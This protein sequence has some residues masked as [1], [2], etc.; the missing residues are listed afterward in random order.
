[1]KNV[2][3][4]GNAVTADILNGYMRRDDR[5]NVL[6]ATVDDQ[7]ADSDD[8]RD[9][10]TIKLSQL[11]TKIRPGDAAVV[12]AVGY[13][14]L[15]RG[16]ESMFQRLKGMGY[17]IETYLHPDAKIYTAVPLGEGSIVLPGALVEPGV[18]VGA[19]TMIWGNVT[20]A[21][22]SSIGENCWIAASAVISGKADI[23]RNTFVGVNATIT[24]GLSIGEYCVIGGGALIT[25]NTKPSTVHLARSA[26]QIRYASQD[27]AKYFGV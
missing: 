23:G 14:D 20:L 4:A 16:R 8:N 11:L 21:H 5:Y 13:D 25:K 22:H 3:L 9:F 6:C 24:N 26:E 2:V 12:I 18:T 27:Y 1:M 7:F 10:K 19:N 15:N 17:Q